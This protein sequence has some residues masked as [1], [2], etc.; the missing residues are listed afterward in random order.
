MTEQPPAEPDPAAAG[1]RDEA[2][3]TYGPA[4]DPR[5]AYPGPDEGGFVPPSDLTPDAY[6]PPGPGYEVD[7]TDRP[8]GPARGGRLRRLL[9]RLAGR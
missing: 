9:S 2:P 5:G 3:A 1:A 4:P 8:E 6:G 7:D